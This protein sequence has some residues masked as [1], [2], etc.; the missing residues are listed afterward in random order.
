[1]KHLNG[2][3]FAVFH[4]L[5]LAALCAA[6]SG[7]PAP[8][9]AHTPTS[10]EAPPP[11]GS[12]PV[13]GENSGAGGF[14]HDAP[15]PSTRSGADY[16]ADAASEA[17]SGSAAD[18]GASLSRRAPSAQRQHEPERR[19][20]RDHERPGLGTVFGERRHAP[21][22]RVPFV[23][24]SERPFATVAVHYNDAEGVAA[25]SRYLGADLGPLTAYTP[26][27][28]VSVALV[29]EYGQLLTG[30]A[31]GGKY[32][33]VGEVGQRYELVIENQSG[34]RYELV[35]SVDGLD[36][37]DGLPATPAKRGY[38]LEPYGQVRIEGWRRSEQHVAAFRFG[39][40]SASYAAR[41]AGD[42]HVGV[43]GVALFAEAGSP[44]TSDELWRRDSADPFPGEHG[45]ARPPRW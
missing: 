41:T 3:I 10:A 17:A 18:R 26:S 38:I 32:L 37:I 39:R 20:Q 21:V 31:A 13:Y 15:A 22:E 43:V 24:A 30:G 16:G 40:V 9:G 42:R 8:R 7:R 25:H 36:V 44:W 12:A 33:V 29:D 34:G 4:G 2:P 28:G 14:G 6:C 5:L 23:R 35:A 19:E 1:M 45:F 11:A 27:G